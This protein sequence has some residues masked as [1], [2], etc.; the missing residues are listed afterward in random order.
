MILYYTRVSN[1]RIRKP[2]TRKTTSPFIFLLLLFLTP[3][4]HAQ[5]CA[6]QNK[7]TAPDSR[8]TDNGDGTITDNT[9][10]LMW[11]QCTEGLTTTTTPCDTGT[12]HRYALLYEKNYLPKV[13]SEKKHA[14]H[15]DWRLPSLDKLKTLQETSCHSPAINSHFFPN[16][17]SSYFWTSEDYPETSYSAYLVYFDYAVVNWDYE[18]GRHYYRLVRENKNSA[19]KK[20]LH[21]NNF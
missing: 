14:G 15:S 6:P 19:N 11:M 20:Q 12:A 16:T 18:T 1:P 2:L 5:T 3:P 8:Y 4:A 7:P 9:T 17:P 10:N 13:N 21:E